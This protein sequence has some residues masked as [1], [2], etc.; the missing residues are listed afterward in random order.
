MLKRPYLIAFTSVLLAV[1]A[2]FCL[3]RN[4]TSQIK[5]VLGDFFLPILG[6]VH[7][8]ETV[9]SKGRDSIIPRSVLLSRMRELLAQNQELTL[10]MMQSTQLWQE[11]Q[12]LREALDWAPKSPWTLKPANVILRDPASWWRTIQ[13]DLGTMDG[14]RTN[15]PVLTDAGLV[16]KI[17]QV[18]RRNSLVLLIGDPQC[19]VSASVKKSSTSELAAYGMIKGSSA[20]ILDPSLVRLTMVDRQTRVEPGDAVETSGLGPVFPKGIPIGRIIDTNTANFGPLYEA[21]ITLA[22][23]LRK[24]ESVWVLFP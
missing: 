2:G 19:P 12:R 13:I 9:L 5:L 22:A 11:N 20:H 7:S 17:E 23:N 15:M 14:V 6:L 1:L 16:G 4:T 18:G 10:H 8:T 21:Q 24:L 3:P